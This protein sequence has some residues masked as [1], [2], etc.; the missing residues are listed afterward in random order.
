M[1]V[2]GNFQDLAATSTAMALWTFLNDPVNI[3]RLETA[4]E[5]W[6]PALEAVATRMNAAFGP[7]IHEYRYRQ[8][9]GHMTKQVMESRGF[10]L[11]AHGIKVRYGRLFSKAS[12]YRRRR[13]RAPRD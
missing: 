2:P 5:L 10:Q 3:V 11:D 13:T 12:R 8:M 1:Y 9:I 7:E 6:R 4:S